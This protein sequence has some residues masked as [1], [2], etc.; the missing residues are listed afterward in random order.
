MQTLT[1]E[2]EAASG[3]GGILYIYQTKEMFQ[4]IVIRKVEKRF[5]HKCFKLVYSWKFSLFVAKHLNS[6]EGDPKKRNVL[7]FLHC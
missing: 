4:N 1:D 2:Q 6:N 7:P 3:L 5:L